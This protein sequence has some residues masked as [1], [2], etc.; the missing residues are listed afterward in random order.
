MDAKPDSILE[1]RLRELEPFCLLP[2]EALLALQ[3]RVRQVRL[4]P[5]RWMVRPRRQLAG[6][7]FLQTG[8]VRLV[9]GSGWETRVEGGSPRARRAVYPG[10]WGVQTLTE[11][12]LLHVDA[13]G[14]N[15]AG[16]ATTTGPG[17][18]ELQPADDGWQ[19]RFLASPLMQHLDYRGW[20]RVLRAMQRLPFGRGERVIQAGAPA[21]GCYVLAAGSAEI[22]SHRL[23]ARIGPGDFF[24]EDAL[25]TQGLR[26]ASVRMLEDGVAM[27]LAAA[28]FDRLLLQVVVLPIA[29]PGDR[30]PLRLRCEGADATA[31]FTMDALRPLARRLPAQRGYCV[32]GANLSRRMLAAFILAQRGIDARPLF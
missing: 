30:I 17:L 4:P 29:A 8:R 5:R 21:D 31:G 23:L 13:T 2:S 18:P 20:Q 11:V 3:Q 24:G 27:R 9:D 16:T 22:R 15:L 19:Q 6:H 25:I 10:P 28:D 7:W 14:L 26:N 32:Q 12:G 1:A